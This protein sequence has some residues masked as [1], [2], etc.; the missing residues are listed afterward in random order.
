MKS[1]PFPGEGQFLGFI[2]DHWLALFPQLLDQSQF[3]RR[4][5]ALQ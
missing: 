5:L 2:R 3:N 4:A 1:L